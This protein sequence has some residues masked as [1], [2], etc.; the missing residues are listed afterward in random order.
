MS[1]VASGR[2]ASARSVC[3][4]AKL[5]AS[6]TDN[7]CTDFCNKRANAVRHA[8]SNVSLVYNAMFYSNARLRLCLYFLDYLAD[9][10]PKT[11]I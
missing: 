4:Y 6:A 3:L 2:R 1:P 9:T 8:P 5:P 11:S 10:C 7:T